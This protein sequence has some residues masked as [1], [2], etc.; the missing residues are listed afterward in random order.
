MNQLLKVPIF[1]GDDLNNI[2][3]YK[4]ILLVSYISWVLEISI[5]LR[6]KIFSI[7]YTTLSTH[8]WIIC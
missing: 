7:K 5:S 1:K 6:T 3:N 4:T 8:Q 2:S